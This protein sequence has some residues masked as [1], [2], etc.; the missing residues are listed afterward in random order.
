MLLSLLYLQNMKST[1][2]NWICEIYR[3]TNFKF[4]DMKILFSVTFQLYLVSIYTSVSVHKMLTFQLF[5][6]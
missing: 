6:L 5:R 1:I 3:I 4:I 2:Q